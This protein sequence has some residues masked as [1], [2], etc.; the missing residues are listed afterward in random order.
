M[1]QRN[2]TAQDAVRQY[3]VIYLRK[4]KCRNTRVLTAGVVLGCR[5]SKRLKF[6]I[7]AAPYQRCREGCGFR[8]P[9]DD[10]VV[11]GFRFSKER[12]PDMP[13]VYHCSPTNSTFFTTC[14]N[15][16]ICDNQQKCPRCRKD[17]YPFSEDM[18]DKER[19]EAA[20]GYYH[21]N[22]HMARWSVARQ[23]R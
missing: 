18:T 20:G 14:C 12:M 1:K 16:A 4:W 13:S 5:K 3:I 10:L 17:V 7:Q 23:R 21:H 8:N 11:T 19:D 6:Y 15:T 2:G 22:T 9:L